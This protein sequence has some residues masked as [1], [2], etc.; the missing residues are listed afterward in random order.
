MIF[1]TKKKKTINCKYCN[2][3]LR[4]PYLKGKTLRVICPHCGRKFEVIFPK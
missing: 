3:K 2:K 1:F 4:V